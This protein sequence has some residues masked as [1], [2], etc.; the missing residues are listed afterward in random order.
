M[1][2]TARELQADLDECARQMDAD[3]NY[4]PY[5]EGSGYINIHTREWE[6]PCDI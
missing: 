1:T 2:S 3:P 6:P 4:V 5:D